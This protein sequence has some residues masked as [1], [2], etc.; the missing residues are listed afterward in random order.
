MVWRRRA[1]ASRP[2][3]AGLPGLPGRARRGPA[4]AQHGPQ[5]GPLRGPLPGRRPGPLFRPWLGPQRGP[6]RDLRLRSRR[7]G[8]RRRS[9]RWRE[10]SGRV[11]RPSGDG[12]LGSWRCGSSPSAGRRRA[13]TRAPAGSRTA[14]RRP[15]RTVGRC[16]CGS[17]S[18]NAGSSWPPQ[19]PARPSQCSRRWTATSSP[20][21]PGPCSLGSWRTRAL[22]LP[23]CRSPPCPSLTAS[24]PSSWDRPRS[25]PRCASWPTSRDS[26]SASRHSWNNGTRSRSRD[27]NPISPHR[28]HG[29][30][31]R[32][33]LAGPIPQPP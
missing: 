14:W 11:D 13:W 31:A 27:V 3:V 30:G 23:P 6:P 29:A 20:S 17:P 24:N 15:V 21:L 32:R 12:R 5:H 2:G 33:T 8:P 4:P 7:A 28:P 25:G 26:W 9:S 19:P 18:Q 22:W 16:W 10:W 1:R